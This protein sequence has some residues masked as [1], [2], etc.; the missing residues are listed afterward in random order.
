MRLPAEHEVKPEIKR[1]SAAETLKNKIGMKRTC[2][3]GGVSV[4]FVLP[5]PQPGS[6]GQLPEVEFPRMDPANP[7]N[8]M[9]TDGVHPTPSGHQFLMQR[10]LAAMTERKMLPQP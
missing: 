10:L 6:G 3:E 4:L 2:E 7:G 5:Y 1:V 9:T 8:P